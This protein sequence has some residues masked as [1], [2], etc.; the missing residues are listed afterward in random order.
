MLVAGLFMVGISG[1]NNR[2][3]NVRHMVW[4]AFLIVSGAAVA[5]FAGTIGVAVGWDRP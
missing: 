1:D 4:G 3:P 5:L 2:A